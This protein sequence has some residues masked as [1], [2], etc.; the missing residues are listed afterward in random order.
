MKVYPCGYAKHA[1]HITSLM[2]EQERLVLIDTRYKPWSQMPAWRREALRAQYG[3]R[4][5]WAGQYLG[6]INYQGGPIALADPATGLRGLRHWLEHGYDLL[7]LCGCA[8]YERCHLHTIVEA[9]KQEV[10]AVEVVLPQ[11]QDTRETGNVYVGPL[12]ATQPYYTSANKRWQAQHACHMTAD[13]L[14]EL[15]AFA[16]RLGL[17]RAWFQN[18]HKNPRY[19]HYDLV[20]SKRRMALAYGAKELTLEQEV[21]RVKAESENP[22][23]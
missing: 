6:N 3:T 17:R 12:F 15:H 13:S 7:L 23:A 5:R 19:W 11:E 18:H 22:H 1:A 2:A 21:A 10:P 16:A 9:L 14:D 4:Y 8:V 20:A